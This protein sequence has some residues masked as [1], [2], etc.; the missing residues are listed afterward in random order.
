LFA[1]VA[2]EASAGI[3]L[4]N[5]VNLLSEMR[6]P[7]GAI[8]AAGILILVGAFNASMTFVSI[9]LSTLFYQS[10]G[11]ARIFSMVV[12]GMPGASLTGA[13]IVE[14]VIGGLSLLVMIN[15]RK[16]PSVSVSSS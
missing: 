16:Q 4:G 14:M 9:L 10:Y 15:L 8:L 1:P 13:T 11:V 2:F 12:D 5:D 3:N 6:A 7:G